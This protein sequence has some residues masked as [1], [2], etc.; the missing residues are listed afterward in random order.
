MQSKDATG[1]RGSIKNPFLFAT[2]VK[3]FSRLSL[4]FWSSQLFRT[5][6]VTP[7]KMFCKC[8]GVLSIDRPSA[9][10]I[11]DTGVSQQLR[12]LVLPEQAPALLGSDFADLLA[13]F[14]LLR[15]LSSV[16]KVEKRLAINKSAYRK[17]K[18]R[19]T[20]AMPSYLCR[21]DCKSCV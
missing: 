12:Y 3:L 2:S 8:S 14:L 4:V 6:H 19:G 10:R 16:C 17:K 15:T 5:H 20:I 7:P 1:T 9:H 18:K 21:I 11:D 13:E